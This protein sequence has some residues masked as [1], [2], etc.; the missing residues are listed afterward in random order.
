MDTR[1]KKDRAIYWAT[2]GMVLFV[3]VYSIITFAFFD[4]ALY[5]EGAFVHLH[6]PNYFRIELTLAKTL[7]V[8]AL[9]I[10]SVPLKVKEFAYF[11][12]A[13][14]LV[15]ASIAHFSVGD[16]GRPPLYAFYIVDPLIFLGMLIVSYRYF[17]KLRKQLSARPMKPDAAEQGVARGVLP[18]AGEI[19]RRPFSD[20]IAFN[21]ESAAQEV[22]RSSAP[23]LVP[24][25]VA[26]GPPAHRGIF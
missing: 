9:L 18:S 15:S 17:H 5:P 19:E 12:F 6:L 25:L 23:T 8:L 22:E 24:G 10:P 14:T 1:M 13:I 3:M 11:G 4:K 16:A 2:T 7:G 20:S 21:S 26:G